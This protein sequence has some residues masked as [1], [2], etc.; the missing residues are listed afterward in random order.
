MIL[1]GLLLPCANAVCAIANRIKSA[2]NRRPSRRYLAVARIAFTRTHLP[3]CAH[4][5]ARSFRSLNCYG[6]LIAALVRL[7]VAFARRVAVKRKLCRRCTHAPFGRVCP[8]RRRFGPDLFTHIFDFDRQLSARSQPLLNRVRRG[9]A[10]ISRP[11][12]LELLD[13]RAGWFRRSARGHIQDADNPS[14]SE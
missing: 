11:R 4:T 6:L 3:P 8:I 10:K 12:G 7:A 9:M 2:V 5:G 14:E 13:N 1:L